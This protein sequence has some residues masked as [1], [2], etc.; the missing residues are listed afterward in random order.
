MEGGVNDRFCNTFAYKSIMQGQHDAVGPDEN[1]RVFR[2]LGSGGNTQPWM[3]EVWGDKLIGTVQKHWSLPPINYKDW[4]NA[5]KIAKQCC[6]VYCT[7]AKSVRVRDSEERVCVWEIAK[8]CCVYC[9]CATEYM[10]V[11]AV[12]R[13]LCAHVWCVRKWTSVQVCSK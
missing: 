1:S 11:C 7:C 13:R 2:L 12:E 4:H 8:S 3:G 10:C 5:W 9:A 6:C